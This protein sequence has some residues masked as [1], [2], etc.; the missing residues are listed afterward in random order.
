MV[1]LR[2][3]YHTRERLR[4]R[5]TH[6]FTYIQVAISSSSWPGGMR[7]SASVNHCPRASPTAIMS[8]AA[9]GVVKVTRR[10]HSADPMRR[11]HH[12]HPLAP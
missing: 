7:R 10:V 12:P 1:F 8:Q 2:T 5:F 9:V 4:G 3:R 11:P 6:W